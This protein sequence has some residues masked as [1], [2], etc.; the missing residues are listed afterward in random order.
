VPAAAPG[1]GVGRPQALAGVVFEAEQGA[2][3][4]V[5]LAIAASSRSAACRARTGTLQADPV[6]QLIQPSQGVAHLEPAAHQLGDPG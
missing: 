3:V 4:R 6:P 1:A 5:H 2:H